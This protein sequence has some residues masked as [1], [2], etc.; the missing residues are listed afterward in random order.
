MVYRPGGG[1]AAAHR[2]CSFGW[3]K[4]VPDSRATLRKNADFLFVANS[5]PGETNKTGLIV[6]RFENNPENHVAVSMSWDIF[7]GFMLTTKAHYEAWL[8]AWYARQAE[9]PVQKK[10]EVPAR[11]EAPPETEYDVMSMF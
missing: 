8:A 1:K 10:Q 4:P 6:P 2:P 5:G 7:S 11:V 9:K 3:E